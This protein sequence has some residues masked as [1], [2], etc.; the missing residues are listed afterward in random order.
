VVGL[1]KKKG[2]EIGRVTLKVNAQQ[3]L[4]HVVTGQ[5]RAAWEF[6]KDLNTCQQKFGR[7]CW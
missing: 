6:E 4:V 1:G 5:L 2:K 3:R 7:L